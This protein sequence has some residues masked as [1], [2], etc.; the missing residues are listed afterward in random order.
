MFCTASPGCGDTHQRTVL[1]RSR[2]FRAPTPRHTKASQ[3]GGA[4]PRLTAPSKIRPKGSPPGS[5]TIRTLR[6][7]TGN[8]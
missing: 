1:R 6:P 5:S 4:A 8:G 7:R 2:C 3:A